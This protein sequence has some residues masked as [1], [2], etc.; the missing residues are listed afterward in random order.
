MDLLYNSFTAL[1]FK[2]TDFINYHKML[3]KPS[4][5]DDIIINLNEI[6]THCEIDEKTLPFKAV[7]FHQNLTKKNNLLNWEMIIDV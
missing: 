7:S 3:K 1:S 5:I 6:I 2:A 4:S